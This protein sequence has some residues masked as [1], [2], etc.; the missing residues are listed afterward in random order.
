MIGAGGHASVLAEALFSINKEIYAFVSPEDHTPKKLFSK[1]KHIKSDEDLNHLSA[2]EYILVNG[3]GSLPG[4]NLRNEIARK[5]RTWGFEFIN[6]IAAS[7]IVSSNCLIGNGVQILTRAVIQPG[8][9]I[10]DDVIIN[11]G[12]IVEHDCQI[13]SSSHLAPGAVLSGG[14]RIGEKVHVGTHATLIQN[15]SIANHC[16][17][18][19]GVTINKNLTTASIVYPAKAHIRSL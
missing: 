3:I 7:A 4:K 13:G 9:I 10:D 11:T 16:I 15:I 18:G 12:V 1:I 5:Y 2:N 14:V 8:C 6:V 19:A 17:I